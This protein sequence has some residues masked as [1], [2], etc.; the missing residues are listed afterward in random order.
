MRDDVR[1]SDLI[2]FRFGWTQLTVNVDCSLTTQFGVI[3]YFSSIAKW[4]KKGTI[5]IDHLI[6][7]Q[8]EYISL[9]STTIADFFLQQFHF[10]RKNDLIWQFIDV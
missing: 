2:H 4:K 6:D 7:L 3:E 8:I 1:T 5:W 9:S 10:S